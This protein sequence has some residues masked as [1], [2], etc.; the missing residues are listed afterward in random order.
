MATFTNLTL[1]T[2]AQSGSIQVTGV[3]VNAIDGLSPSGGEGRTAAR[4]IRGMVSA[5]SPV[6]TI[7]GEQVVMFRKKNKKGKPV[8][9]ARLQGYKII[10]STA[11]DAATAGLAANYH[12][13]AVSTKHARK[14]TIPAPTHVTLTAAY[15]ATTNTVTLTLVGK[16]E[17]AK[18]GELTVIYVPPTGVSSASEVPL[19]SSDARLTIQRKGTGITLD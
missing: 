3:G 5:N 4:T 6:P 2:T 12:M 10:Y 15:D 8:G 11:M 7:I 9:K 19:A 1:D 13:T 14:K 18:G 16:Q 17:F